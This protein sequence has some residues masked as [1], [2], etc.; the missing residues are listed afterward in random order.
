M[1]KFFIILFCMALTAAAAEKDFSS[2]VINVGVIVSDMEKSLTFYK[3]VIG[4]IQ[5]E[6]RTSFDVDENFAAK[7]G[8]SNGIPFHVEVLKLGTGDQATEFKLMTF[9]DRSK[10]QTNEF[11]Y[12]HTGMQYITIFVT[13][14]DPIIKRIQQHNIRM[15]GETPTPLG[16][17]RH[18]VLVKDP[19][20]TF[21]ELI[22]PKSLKR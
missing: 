12:D 11:I 6:G 3:D 1:K 7:S 22:G 13:E 5:E 17:D 8:L 18:F 4:M 16:E 19:D 15:L 14:L 9:K 2:K 10:K 21:V 20:G